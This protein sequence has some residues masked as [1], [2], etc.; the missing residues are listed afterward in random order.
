MRVKIKTKKTRIHG[1][2]IFRFPVK[3]VHEHKRNPRPIATQ[4]PY[5]QLI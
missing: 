1:A 5:G 2:E 3:I 4:I